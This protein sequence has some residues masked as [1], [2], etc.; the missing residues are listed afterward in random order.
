M[1]SARVEADDVEAPQR[2]GGPAR[3]R[4]RGERVMGGRR[5]QGLTGMGDGDEAGGPGERWPDRLVVAHLEIAD[6]DRHACPLVRPPRRAA[7]TA[8]IGSANTA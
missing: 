2:L 8:W 7:R 4:G 3:L 1:C 6:V 5:Q